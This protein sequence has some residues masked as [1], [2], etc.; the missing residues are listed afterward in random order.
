[1]FF[2]STFKEIKNIVTNN[3]FVRNDFENILQFKEY[4]KIE[5]FYYDN[6][7]DVFSNYNISGIWVFV[8]M[9]ILYFVLSWII[10]QNVTNKIQK[11]ED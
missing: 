6:Y 10:N 5:R 3:F 8:F 7:V 1:M 9:C 2:L 11:E 4:K